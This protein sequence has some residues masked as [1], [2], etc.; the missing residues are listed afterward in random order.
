MAR[1]LAQPSPA[2]IFDVDRNLLSL[3][4]ITESLAASREDLN[5]LLEEARLS[6]SEEAKK[7]VELR[8]TAARERLAQ[9]RGQFRDIVGGV[10]SSAFE[11]EEE[12]E[13]TLQEQ[14]SELLEPLVGALREPTSRLRETEGM[15]DSLEKWSDRSQKSARVLARIDDLAKAVADPQVKSELEAARRVWADRQTEAAGQSRI[16]GLRIAEREMTTPSL[17]ESFSRMFSEFWKNRGLNLLIALIV[18][19]AGFMAVRRSYQWLRSTRWFRHKEKVTLTGRVSDLLS[20]VV[21]VLV[22]TVAVLLVFYLRGDWLLLTLVAVLL[23]GAAWAGKTALPPYLEQIRMLLNMGVVREG[24]RVVYQELPW[25]VKSLGFFTTF[26]NPDLE[27]GELRIPLLSV[28]KMISREA[29]PK[30]PWFPSRKDDWVILTEGTYGKVV[31]QT[32]EQVTLVKLGGSLITYP[33]VEFLALMPENLSHGFRVT[34]VFGID[35]GHQSIATDEVVE[36]LTEAL[37]EKL[38]NDYGK[39]GVRSVKVEFQ[40][41]G[42]S[43]L[44][45]AVLADFGGDLASRYRQLE[46]KV[47]QVCVEVCNEQDW[48]IPF[49]QLTLHQSLRQQDDPLSLKSY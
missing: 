41:A 9:Y 4:A 47:Q 15:R 31:R 19:V 5:R 43:S 42:A 7:E 1:S 34:S 27:G 29:D 24:E 32:P 36:I 16:L 38:T 40:S 13:V 48:V 8:I 25:K 37:F 28:M 49:P 39:D 17:W 23:I 30:E 12:I 14:F 35:Y 22:A 18:A 21:A 20:V 46:R 10:E 6:Q 45:Y 11:V 26:S 33:T 44:N 2:P 3:N